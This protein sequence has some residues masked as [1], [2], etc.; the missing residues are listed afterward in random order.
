MINQQGT[1][2]GTRNGMWKTS[3]EAPRNTNRN[4]ICS[5]QERHG[6]TPDPPR[7]H[8]WVLVG[9][10]ETYQRL[11]TASAMEE[12]QRRSL[13]NRVSPRGF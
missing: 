3:T 8:L 5:Q 13:L 12:N 6:A 1:A 4:R 2:N 10:L 7:P 11:E 9:L